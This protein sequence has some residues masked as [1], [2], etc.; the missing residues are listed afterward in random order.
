MCS[1]KPATLR[2][3][4]HEINLQLEEVK[5]NQQHNAK[6]LAMSNIHGSSNQANS[7]S[8]S[9]DKMMHTQGLLQGHDQKLQGIEEKLFGMKSA[10]TELKTLLNDIVL[11]VNFN[12]N[13]VNTGLIQ[14][15]FNPMLNGNISS[16]FNIFTGN[17]TMIHSEVPIPILM[18]FVWDQETNLP[19]Y[20]AS[21]VAITN[22]ITFPN[23]GQSTNPMDASWNEAQYPG[24]WFDPYGVLTELNCLQTKATNLE[25]R[26]ESQSKLTYRWSNAYWKSV[27]GESMSGFS[28]PE[29]VTFAKEPTDFS[30]PF[31][32][33]YAPLPSYNAFREDLLS[34]DDQSDEN[35]RN[36]RERSQLEQ[37][38]QQ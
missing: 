35:K 22:T 27:S 13:R 18:P 28:F 9:G 7:M 19:I 29:S 32:R 4:Q 31:T 37:W 6:M 14:G 36:A 33:V 10:I 12:T 34:S 24:W 11:K 26:Y 21:G 23:N 20:D 15:Q 25:R 16:K 30:D 38:C 3:Q 8:Y 2:K 17:F 1:A 5:I